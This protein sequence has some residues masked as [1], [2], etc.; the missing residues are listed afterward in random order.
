MAVAATKRG[1]EHASAVL[2]VQGGSWAVEQK[3][4]G[5]W[6]AYLHALEVSI[7]IVIIMIIATIIIIVASTIIIIIINIKGARGPWSRSPGDPGRPTFMPMRSAMMMMMMMMII[8]IIIIIIMMMMMMMIIII[9]IIII[10]PL[11]ITITILILIFFIIIIIIT[12]TPSV[13]ALADAAA[14]DQGVELISAG[15]GRGRALP[16]KRK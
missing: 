9:I 3:P 14:V 13:P 16:A 10:S 6:Q 7:I 1:E 4:R 11:I 15:R 12:I 5:P 2:G 8:I